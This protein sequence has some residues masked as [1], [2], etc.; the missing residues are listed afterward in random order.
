MEDPALS[1]VRPLVAATTL[2]I[3]VSGTAIA[4]DHGKVRSF[5]PI[6]TF[7]VTGEVAEIVAAT[8]DGK[9]LIYTDSAVGEIGF[10]DITD[11]A[12]PQ[13]DG[14]LPVAGSPTAVAVSKNGAWA[15]VTVDQTNGVFTS[16]AGVLQVVRLSDRTIVRTIDLHG[17]PDSIA[18]S[19]DGRYAAIAI[20]NQRDEEFVPT[21]GGPP[22]LPAGNLTIVDL[23][24]GPASWTLRTVDLTGLKGATEPSD[25]EPEFVDINKDNIVAVTLQENNAVA[26]VK[27]KTGKVIR[28]WSAGSTRHKAD[29]IDDGVIDFA[30]ILQE[31]REPDAIGWTPDGRLMTAN[32]GDWLGGSRDVTIFRKSGS[33]AWTSGSSLERAAAAAGF[34]N[35]GRSDAKGIEPEG[36]EIGRFGHRTF[37]FVGAERGNFVGVYRL[38]DHH[39][40]QLIQLLPTGVRP[41]GL[42]AIPGRGLFVS[43]NEDDG[44]I[45]IFRASAAS[46]AP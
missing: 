23:K 42:L 40:P 36:L 5:V 43:A 9:T 44:T 38:H 10:V 4:G 26:L 22:Q 7:E 1:I 21:D 29:T 16:P 20:E 15:L 34:Y 2:A 8:K 6:A 27:L 41:E 28:S 13:P 33:V 19:P 30:D 18:V 25:P 11:P 32:E 24:H 3:L 14:S 31:E 35:D 17:Q 45:S 39:R 12:A 37:A 46:P